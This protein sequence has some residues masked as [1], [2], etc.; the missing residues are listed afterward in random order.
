MTETPLLCAVQTTKR[1]KNF[2]VNN[3]FTTGVWPFECYVDGFFCDFPMELS[4]FSYVNIFL[5][6][7]TYRIVFSDHEIS[8]QWTIKTCWRGNFLR[9]ILPFRF[10]N[11]GVAGGI[12]VLIFCR[13]CFYFF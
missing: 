2:L 7:S 6:D 13:F 5:F 9:A 12:F 3:F 10:H 11:F 8:G 4:P 1:N